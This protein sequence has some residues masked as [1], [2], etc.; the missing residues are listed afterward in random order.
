MKNQILRVD[1]HQMFRDGLRCR[2]HDPK[3][4]KRGE[5]YSALHQR[6]HFVDQGSVDL[7]H[8]RSLFGGVFVEF[9]LQP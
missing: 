5:S 1:E 8:I 3:V 7:H 9:L 6:A 2:F 4:S